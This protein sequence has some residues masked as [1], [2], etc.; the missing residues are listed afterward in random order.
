MTDGRKAGITA[1]VAFS[2]VLA[3]AQ[4][5]ASQEN[6]SG[7]FKCNLDLWKSFKVE[8]FTEKFVGKCLID[9]EKRNLFLGGEKGKAVPDA[10]YKTSE[11]CETFLG[12]AVGLVNTALSTSNCGD[13]DLRALGHFDGTVGAGLTGDLVVLGA[14][15][16]GLERAAQVNP[17]LWEIM[18][19]IGAANPDMAGAPGTTCTLCDDLRNGFALFPNG[20]G[21]C[22]QYACNQSG[23]VGVNISLLPVPIVTPSTG[24]SSMTLCQWGPAF[25]DDIAVFGSPARTS[26]DFG[27]VHVCGVTLETR[28]FIR[29]SGSL[30]TKNVEVCQD[31]LVGSCSITNN[32]PCGDNSHCPA[33]ETCS[34]VD[35]CISTGSG[36]GPFTPTQCDLPSVEGYC[37]TTTG[38]AC[39]TDD[40]C[41]AAETCVLTGSCSVTTATAC[42]GDID[43]PATETCDRAG[44]CSVT[45]ATACLGDIDC[46]A[47]ETCDGAVVFT[48]GLCERTVSPAS[49]AGGSMISQRS[50]AQLVAGPDFG[51]DGVP[52]TPDDTAPPAAPSTVLLTTG[53]A[54]ATIFNSDTT[55]GSA[56]I[57]TLTGI[58]FN[59]TGAARC[60]V[61][62]GTS[63]TVDADC[64]VSEA[65]F[66]SVQAG[67]LGGSWVSG[68]AQLSSIVTGLGQFD[69]L[70]GINIQCSN[71]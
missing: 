9:Y 63:C 29:N 28:G 21:P 11:L 13:D 37:S 4:P 65:C 38:T 49:V 33:T 19:A 44:S 3:V 42:L 50:L 43:C 30:S 39:G 51:V 69:V 36:S 52:C 23:S 55:A 5:V 31:H 17:D 41:P 57:A 18:E 26:T 60:S 16:H 10:L 8:N 62:T 58:P 53:S 27:V 66:G 48:G 24:T 25:G 15:R 64:P 45:T 32:K 46:P 12:K 59:L 40:V 70:T 6:G 68:G 67:S 71:P 56:S 7:A 20:A 34:D 1:A 22:Q 14:L 35:E 54:D 47:T 2:L 61:T